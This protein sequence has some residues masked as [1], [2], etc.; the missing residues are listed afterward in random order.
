MTAL[1]TFDLATAIQGTGLLESTPLVLAPLLVMASFVNDRSLLAPYL[2]DLRRAPLLAH[3]AVIHAK[4]LRKAVRSYAYLP[5]C[6]VDR[7]RRN[8]SIVKR[9]SMLA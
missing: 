8:A 3:L 1:S 5:G 9:L 6:L 4:V 7:M 2:H